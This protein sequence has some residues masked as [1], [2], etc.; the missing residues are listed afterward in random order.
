MGVFPETVAHF[1]A[2]KG[3]QILHFTVDS[4]RR[5]RTESS[6]PES[7]ELSPTSG[8][9]SSLC[10]AKVKGGGYPLAACATRCS[11]AS[12]LQEKRSADY[13]RCGAR[14]RRIGSPCTTA[15]SYPSRST[16]VSPTLPLSLSPVSR[17]NFI[18]T[19]MTLL[20]FS[21]GCLCTVAPDRIL[22]TPWCVRER[23][24]QS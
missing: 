3:L 16:R 10:G 17:M 18:K 15:S 11:A 2:L 24:R 19:V 14:R 20:R 23:D 6:P 21:T 4:Q 5:Q 12:D 8:G 22:F 1:H 9:K 13:P 7:Q